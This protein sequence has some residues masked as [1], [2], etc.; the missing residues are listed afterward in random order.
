MLFL[1][2]VDSIF[3]VSSFDQFHHISTSILTGTRT[4]Q[5]VQSKTNKAKIERQS[6]AVHPERESA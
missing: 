5:Y 1:F 2:F 6:Y 4:I 3:H